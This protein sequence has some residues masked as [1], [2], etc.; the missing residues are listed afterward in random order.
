MNYPFK[1][2][3]KKKNR[4][5]HRHEQA[6]S[7]GRDHRTDTLQAKHEPPKKRLGIDPYAKEMAKRRTPL[8]RHVTSKT[9]TPRKRLGIDPYA[10]ENGEKTNPSGIE[11]IWATIVGG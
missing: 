3:N 7:A 5:N 2:P 8:E 4:M 9:L 11:L 10:N 6:L 1:M